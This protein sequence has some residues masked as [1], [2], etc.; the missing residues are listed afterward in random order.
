[1]KEEESGQPFRLGKAATSA[2]LPLRFA[3]CQLF[4]P[5]AS[6]AGVPN[7]T[8]VFKLNWASGGGLVD[9]RIF[10]GDL[11][12]EVNEFVL[13]PLSGRSQE[14][15]FARFKDARLGPGH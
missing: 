14:Y 11:G 5:R 8:R 9:R 15:G 7:P 2:A 13:I 6:A 3:L 4:L 12:P 1:M 10:E